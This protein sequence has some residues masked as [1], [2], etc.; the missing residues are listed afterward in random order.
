MKT[1]NQSKAVVV[2]IT[3]SGEEEAMK[4]GQSLVDKKL[5]ACANVVPGIR[6]IFY[7]KGELC[8]EAEVLLIVKS[9]DHLLDRIVH[10]VRKLHSY[11][12][13]EIIA[14]PIVGGS[15]EYLEW[16]EASLI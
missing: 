4:I 11:D 1:E 10:N 7:W 9:L 16:I 12:V 15:E 14:L 5:A 13:P 8:E 6:S 2:F 3:A